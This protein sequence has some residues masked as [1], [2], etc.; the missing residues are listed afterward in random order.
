MQKKQA[1]FV[2]K[3]NIVEMGLCRDIEDEIFIL[4]FCDQKVKRGSGG[5]KK[6]SVTAKNDYQSFS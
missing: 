2:K 5:R 1:N 3:L 6:S 4:L